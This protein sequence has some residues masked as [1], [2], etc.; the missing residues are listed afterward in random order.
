MAAGGWRR[1]AKTNIFDGWRFCISGNQKMNPG[2]ENI[3]ICHDDRPMT[4]ESNNT[5]K[6]RK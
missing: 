2:K 3:R 1:H 4:S 6:H 5:M